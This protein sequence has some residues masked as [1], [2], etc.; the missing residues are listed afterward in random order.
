MEELG[1]NLVCLTPKHM[2]FNCDKL[3]SPKHA[4][5]GGSGAPKEC[6]LG[7]PP[8]LPHYH[9]SVATLCCQTATP[10]NRPQNSLIE[11][12]GLLSGDF[13]NLALWGQNPVWVPSPAQTGL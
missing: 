3:L 2:P 8:K 4:V 10:I 9:L 12:C 6:L 1:L 13:L 7:I 5:L 11:R